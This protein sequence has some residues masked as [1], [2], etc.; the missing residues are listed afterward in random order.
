MMR[1]RGLFVFM[2]RS[3]VARREAKSSFW[4]ARGRDEDGERAA[5]ARRGLDPE[6]IAQYLG[7]F[8]NHGQTQAGAPARGEAFCG[9][10]R[11][12]NPRQDVGRD[13]QTR[14]LNRE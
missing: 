3:N 5:F 8:I 7:D 9:E 10:K 1:I 14:I 12:E 2:G 11:L 4:R 13:A 6:A